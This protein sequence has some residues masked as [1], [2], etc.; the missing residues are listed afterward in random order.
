MSPEIGTAVFRVF[1]AAVTNVLRHAEA[2]SL[3]VSL[4]ATEE[5]L[6]LTLEDDGIGISRDRME[7]P[8]AFGIVGM[9]DL[10]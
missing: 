2:E 4:H 8:N 10:S 6:E 9:Q 3:E 7:D 5:K 1:Q